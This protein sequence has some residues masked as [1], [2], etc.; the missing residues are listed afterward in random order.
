MGHI[1]GEVGQRLERMGFGVIS[2]LSRKLE[3][4]IFAEGCQLSRFKA[5]K[6]I[7][8]EELC[9]I[10]FEEW[11]VVAGDDHN[12]VFASMFWKRLNLGE[13]FNRQ[14]PDMHI[15]TWN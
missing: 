11:E 3:D 4:F 15:V 12:V 10:F 7:G 5:D 13:A 14:E 6:S 8:S 1:D 2:D 9:E